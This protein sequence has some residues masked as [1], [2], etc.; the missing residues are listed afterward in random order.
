MALTPCSGDT[1]Q[2]FLIEEPARGRTAENLSGFGL[3]PKF[4]ISFSLSFVRTEKHEANSNLLCREFGC[5]A[6]QQHPAAGR[7]QLK[8]PETLKQLA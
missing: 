7:W 5:S 8:R 4:F 1:R 6:S 3:H 2:A